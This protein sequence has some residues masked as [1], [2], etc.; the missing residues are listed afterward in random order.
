[1]SQVDTWYMDGTFSIAQ[2]I[3][4]EVYVISAPLGGTAVS[5]VNALMSGKHQTSYE[6]MLQAVIRKFEEYGYYPDA[7]TVVMDFEKASA[8]R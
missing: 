2:N 5:C 7:T 8:H 3:F 6:E 4:T 1:M